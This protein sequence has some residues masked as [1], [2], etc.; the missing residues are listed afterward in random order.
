MPNEHRITLDVGGATRE[1]FPIYDDLTIQQARVE[2]EVFMRGT[3][4]TEFTF[5]RGDFDYL[6]GLD[7]D[8]E[9]VIIIEKAV[10]VPTYSGLGYSGTTVN[11]TEKWRGVFTKTDCEWDEDA[12]LVK[13]KPRTRDDYEKVMEA[14]NKEFNL[15]DLAPAKT[16]VNWFKKPIIQAYLFD[17]DF[18]A[19]FTQGNYW[20]SPVVGSTDAIS[21]V[22]TYYFT[23]G[24]DVIYIPGDS[25]LNPDVSGKY[26][27]ATGLREDGVYQIIAGT[28]IT[29]ERVSDG[30]TMYT[31]VAGE[32]FLNATNFLEPAG[33]LTS[34]IDGTSQVQGFRIS[35]YY[36]YF[37]DQEVI[38]GVPTFPVPTN[39]IVAIN[40]NYTRVIGLSADNA[41]PFS[42]HQAEPTPYGVFD[43]DADNFAGEYFT[44]YTPAGAPA[45]GAAYP[46]S[47]SSWGF[48]SLWFFFDP[49]LIGVEEDY[50]TYVFLEDAY[51]LPD[52][53]SAFLSEIDSSLTHEETSAYSMF[54]YS[55]SAPMRTTRYYPMMTPKS[56]V[57]V[58]NYDQPAKRA[59]LRFGEILQL[60]KDFYQVYWHIDGGKFKLEHIEYFEKG[61]SYAMDNIGADLTVELNP[62]NRKVWAYETAKY[63]YD[64]AEMPERIE[65]N[66]MDPQSPVF[67]G[68]PIEMINPRVEKGNVIQKSMA[69]FAA[70]IDYIQTNGGEISTEG[71]VWMEAEKIGR[72]GFRS[73]YEIPTVE[74]VFD[75]LTLNIQNGLATLAYAHEEYHKYRLPCEDVKINNAATTAE[76]VIKTKIQEIEFPDETLTNTIQLVTTTLGNGKPRRREI[77]LISNMTKTTLYHDQ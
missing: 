16:I 12:K 63:T 34:N 64:K 14:L 58:G 77:D 22:N 66:W 20:E 44:Q 67:E 33:S 6:L 72:T 3:L 54:F 8:D 61:G 41:E 24:T 5:V 32:D 17:S 4:E 59:P 70:D 36:R 26:S 1:V 39:D 51:R 73:P 29:I 75:N 38:A 13:V 76:S 31:G 53:V 37:T 40:D 60:L 43:E 57:L 56:N 68:Y 9:I 71:F 30:A 7:I 65:W 62:K 45:V 19:N 21:L 74:I 15:I 2:G 49:F 23:L 42:G 50:S 25:S 47:R 52:V 55:T 18:V 28:P 48:Y 11:Y 27:V 35:V 46:L 69:R 10:T